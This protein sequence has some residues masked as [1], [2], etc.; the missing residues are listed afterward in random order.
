[1]RKYGSL[2]D[3]QPVNNVVKMMIMVFL[4]KYLYPSVLPYYDYIRLLLCL[5]IVS[6]SPC[7]CNSQVYS[8]IK[9]TALNIL[10][11]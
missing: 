10:K 8:Q 4:I 2:A 5:V 1:M 9:A 6:C 11:V 3:P 7:P